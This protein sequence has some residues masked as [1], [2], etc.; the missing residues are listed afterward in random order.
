MQ[1]L[2][3]VTQKGQITLPKN[4][5]DS[6]KIKSYSRVIIENA[7]SHIKIYPTEDIIDLAGSLIPIKT[8]PIL[9]SR[10]KF[11]KNYKRI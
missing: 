10:E 1:V 5:R 4:F 6:L 8:R 7:N 2:T 9:K 11:E 3:T